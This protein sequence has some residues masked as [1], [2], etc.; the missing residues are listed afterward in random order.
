[1]NLLSMLVVA[2]GCVLTNQVNEMCLTPVAAVTEEARNDADMN[3]RRSPEALDVNLTAKAVVVWDVESGTTLYAKEA[4]TRRPVAS[5]SKLLSVLVVREALSPT[6]LVEIPPDVRVAQRL[7]VNIRLPVGGHASVESLLAASLIA[8]AND[9]V[10]S[11]AV[12]AYGDE[13]AFVSAANTYAR[14]LG[15]NQTHLANATGL[16]GGEQYSTADDVRRLLTLVWADPLLGSYLDNEKGSLATSE[17]V[18]RQY[19]TTNELLSTY[20]PVVAAKTGYTTEAGENVALVT[21]VGQNH[22]IGMVILGSTQRFQ[23]AKILAEWINRYY[24]WSPT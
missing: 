12:A 7:G 6:T 18:V 16:T 4:T 14:T 3:I 17:G 21:R 11:L 1:M 22:V 20:L 2:M 8:S 19:E 15:L 10:V 23:D 13:E 5:L 24:T 9:A